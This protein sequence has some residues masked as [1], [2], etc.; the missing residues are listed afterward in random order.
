VLTTA[1]QPGKLQPRLPAIAPSAAQLEDALAAR[2]AA[3]L[4]VRGFAQ[5]AYETGEDNVGARHAVLARRPDHFRLE[6]LSPFGALAV[7]ATDARELVVYA[8]REAKIYRGPAS[9][10]SVATY[11]QVPVGVDDVTAIL[12]GTP[13][14]RAATG[15]AIVSRDEQA[16]AF[17]LTI[18]IAGGKE[19]IWFEPETLEPVASE[20][21]LAD[22]V[23]LRVAFGDYKAI[24]SLRF[25]HAIDMRADP[26]NH[27]VRVRYASP[28]L[29]T[30]IADTLFSF[31]PREGLEEL[32]I[33]Q[34]PVAGE[35]R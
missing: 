31:P 16:H 11:T 28:S 14:A 33:Q 1:C 19:L 18:P 13:P 2:R 4:S 6:V 34:Y 8:R 5:I 27:A 35:Q 32:V 23:R 15:P 26:G 9:A 7:I 20:T 3:V 21:P 12:L 25:P 17:K 30:E 22:G 24:G 29:N 10:G